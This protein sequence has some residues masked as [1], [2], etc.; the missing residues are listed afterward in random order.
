MEPLPRLGALSYDQR[1][2]SLEGTVAFRRPDGSE[3]EVRAAVTVHPHWPF[4][5]VMREL[6][7]AAHMRAA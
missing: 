7:G 4:D 6:I 3:R 1:T 2:C 5:R